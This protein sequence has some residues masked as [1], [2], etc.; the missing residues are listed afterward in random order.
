MKN[1]SIL[2]VLLALLL[3]LLA[4]ATD[5]YVATDGNDSNPG[6]L[7]EPFAT[8]QKAADEMS[9]GDTCYIRT[10]SYH[11]TATMQSKNGTAANPITFTNY[12]DEVVELNGTEEITSNWTQHSGNIYKTTL[13]GDVWQLFVDD[14]MMIPARWPNAFLHADSIWDRESNWGY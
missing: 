9:A 10:G 14:E 4:F 12:Q 1:L 7:A 13:P 6:T 11:E 3:C 2:A 5:Y 8:I